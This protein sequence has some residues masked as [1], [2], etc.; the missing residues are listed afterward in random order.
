MQKAEEILKSIRPSVN[1]FYSITA[2]HFL[3]SGEAGLEHFCFLLNT[4]IDDINNLSI[5][6]L[7]SVWACILYKG[8]EK[9]RNNHRSYRTISTCPF[10]S[11]SIDTYIASLYSSTWNKFT[12]ET[13][14]QQKASS[15][16]LASL[17]LTEAILHSTNTLHKPVYVLYL[18]ARSAFDLALREFIINNLYDYGIQDQGLILI[19]QRLRNRRTICEWNKILMGPILDECGVEQGGINSS[20]FYK[21]HNNDQLNLAQESGFGVPLGPVTVSGIG[22]ADDVALAA[23]DLNSLQG[24]VDLSSYYCDKYHVSLSTEKT[25]LQVFSNKYTEDEAFLAKSTSL[26]NIDGQPINFVDN[27]EHVGV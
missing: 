16:E 1:D 25:K 13:Q 18:D 5:E 27:A 4:I 2:S 9:D 12:S 3:N 21:V 17:T 11:K 14:F 20:D 15:H 26:L 6:E 8:H 10:L 19:D 7:N 22:Q 24:L 23:N